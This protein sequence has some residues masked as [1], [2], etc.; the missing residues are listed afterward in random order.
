MTGDV[1]NLL[2]ALLFNSDVYEVVS[3]MGPV[4]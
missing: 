3:K 4:V 2:S 1:I